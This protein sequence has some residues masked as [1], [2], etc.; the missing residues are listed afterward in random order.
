MENDSMKI[1]GAYYSILAIFCIAIFSIGIVNATD[2]V[3]SSRPGSFVSGAGH[4]GFDLTNVTLQQE[5]LTRFQQQGTD[6]TGLQSAFQSGNMTDVKEWMK[7]H[8]PAGAAGTGMKS[9]HQGFDLT[10][11]TLQQE[12]L[13]RF[14]QQG[15]DVTG[16]Q[17]A[18]QSGNMTDVKEWMKSHRPVGAAGT[19]MMSGRQ[20]FDLTNVTL[21]QEMLTRFQQQG[22][23]VT[24]LQSAFQSGNLTDVK[25]WMKS[26][27]PA[28]NATRPADAAFRFGRAAGTE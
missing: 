10:N 19:G 26:H 22:I 1:P 24:G 2:H 11:V 7:T 21:Q 28:T 23:D 14:Q 16:L 8:R 5:M 27:R 18:F 13:T 3:Q 17:A 15:I 20:A 4:Q 6:V 12:M 9:G 25:E